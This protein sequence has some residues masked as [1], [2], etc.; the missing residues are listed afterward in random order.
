M[1]A[2]IF[3][4][5][6]LPRRQE[7]MRAVFTDTEAMSKNPNQPHRRYMFSFDIS[8]ILIADFQLENFLL[9]YEQIFTVYF[10]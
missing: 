9:P 10:Y 5:T 2:A 7:R 6:N 8:L 3:S 1:N 4:L